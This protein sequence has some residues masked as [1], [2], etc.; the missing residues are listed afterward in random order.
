MYTF[1]SWILGSFAVGLIAFAGL[2]AVMPN[3]PTQ[4]STP[5]RFGSS[6]DPQ[7]MTQSERPAFADCVPNED[8]PRDEI[9]SSA[10]IR[11]G[12]RSSLTRVS[13]D[14]AMAVA[15]AKKSWFVASCR[16]AEAP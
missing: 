9:P 2:L 14:E 13:F 3:E 8:W 1:R 4:P 11:R 7:Q 6:A 16:R 15:A 12:D 5:A 10:L